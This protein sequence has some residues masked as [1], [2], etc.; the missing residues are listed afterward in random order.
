M[1]V[2]IVIL[3]IMGMNPHGGINHRIFFTHCHGPE[4]GSLI[5]AGIDNQLHPGGPGVF[6]HRFAVLIKFLIVDMGMAVN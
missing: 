5:G 4:A 1:F 2:G 6:Q 3:G